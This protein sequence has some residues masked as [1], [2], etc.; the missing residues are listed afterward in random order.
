MRKGQKVGIAGTL[1]LLAS[2]LMVLPPS[3][4][5]ISLPGGTFEIA[6][7]RTWSSISPFSACAH[8]LARRE[9]VEPPTF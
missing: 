5:V 7:T 1:T 8:L 4:V 3:A 6:R 9:G 2:L